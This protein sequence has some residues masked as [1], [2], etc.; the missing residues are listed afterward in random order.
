MFF[1]GLI[2]SRP[3]LAA[4]AVLLLYALNGSFYMLLLR[5]RG[6]RQAAVGV[7]LH[8][9]HHVAGAAAVPVAGM[10]YLIERLGDLSRSAR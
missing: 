4:A 9:L 10:L 2:R 6:W 3:R 7:P 5:R 8:A 1:I